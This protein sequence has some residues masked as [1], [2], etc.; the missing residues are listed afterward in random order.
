MLTFYNQRRVLMKTQVGGHFHHHHKPIISLLIKSVT[1]VLRFPAK[2]V[3]I[4]HKM[5][6]IYNVCTF[7]KELYN[8]KYS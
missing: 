1:L 6:S 3:K 4:T 2:Y 7:N 8:S 5:V